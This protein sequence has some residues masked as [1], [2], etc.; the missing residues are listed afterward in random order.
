MEIVQHF[1]SE[2]ED[3]CKESNFQGESLCGIR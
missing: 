1:E 3:D 2:L